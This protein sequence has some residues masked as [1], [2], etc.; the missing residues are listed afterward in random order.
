MTVLFIAFFSC[1]EN[2]ND[3]DLTCVEWEDSC[4]GC[5]WMCTDESQKPDVVC[6]IECTEEHPQEE[7]VR[8]EENICAFE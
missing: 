5:T 6:D 1:S 7:C 2:Q 4:S 8:T 3:P